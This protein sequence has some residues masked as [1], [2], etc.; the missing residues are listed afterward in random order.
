MTAPRRA[1]DDLLA[2][3]R[4]DFPAVRVGVPRVASAGAG[5][6]LWFFR[7][8]GS[9]FAV[10]VHSADGEPPLHIESDEGDARHSAKSAAEA[11]QLIVDL[12]HLEEDE[13]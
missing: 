9:P 2:R 4:N 10:Q 5:G 13:P 3:V 1:I 7:H 12:L 6:G 11:L 8:S